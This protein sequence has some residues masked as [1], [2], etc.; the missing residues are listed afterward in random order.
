MPASAAHQVCCAL[1]SMELHVEQGSVLPAF[2]HLFLS[3]TDAPVEL[4]VPVG[5][6][7]GELM[8]ATLIAFLYTAQN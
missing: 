3:N 1:C 8:P 7:L 4:M 5:E 6:S 2:R